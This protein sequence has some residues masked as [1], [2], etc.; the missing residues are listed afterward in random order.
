MHRVRRTPFS[1]DSLAGT[2]INLLR[3]CRMLSTV[4]F[5]RLR[6]LGARVIFG[7]ALVPSAFGQ[8]E[9]R[10]GTWTANRFSPSRSLWYN[11]KAGCP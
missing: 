8:A 10:P 4:P 6:W 2:P 3:K 11:A 5:Q 7:L 1:T 9:G